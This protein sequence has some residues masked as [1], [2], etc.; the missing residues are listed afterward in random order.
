MLSENGLLT[1]VCYRLDGKTQYAFEGAVETA[2]A[3]V[4]WAKSVGLV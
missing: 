3:A 4:K 2:G 1:T